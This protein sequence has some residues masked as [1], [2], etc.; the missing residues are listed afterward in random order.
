MDLRLMA[1]RYARYVAWA[2]RSGYTPLDWNEYK[3]LRAKFYRAA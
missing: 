1:Q 2:K 3:A